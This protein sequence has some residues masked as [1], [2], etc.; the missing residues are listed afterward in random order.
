MGI[1]FFI[2]GALLK[3]YP[4]PSNSTAAPP[5]ASKAMAAMLYVYVCFYS[6]G[7]GPAAWIYVSD[8]FNT[9]TRHYGLATASASQWLF[10]FILSKVTPTLVSA[11]G[12]KLFLMFG[13]IN[14]LGM[15]TF[16][17]LI[18]ETK[19]R[20]LEEMDIIFGTVA[21]S[22]RE[23]DIAKQERAYECARDTSSN[24]SD[25]NLEKV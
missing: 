25:T 12:Y 23:A 11:L 20:S 18:P 9:R 19:G 2:V 22:D 4:P 10:N 1:S 16:A 8:I 15:G 13:A 3:T 7:C 21:A 6:M 5:P 14:V 17:L 24:R